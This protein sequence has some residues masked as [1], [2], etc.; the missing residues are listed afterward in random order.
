M[1]SA[2]KKAEPAKRKATIKETIMMI[3]ER[4]FFKRKF[5][6]DLRERTRRY[7]IRLV[8]AAA[9]NV[10]SLLVRSNRIFF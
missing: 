9:Y 8:I 6:A 7:G 10:G 1:G 2:V 3:F 4:L 5:L